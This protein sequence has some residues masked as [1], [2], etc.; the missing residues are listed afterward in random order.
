M[1][2]KDG[3]HKALHEDWEVIRSDPLM[4]IWWV[5]GI[6]CILAGFLLL[7]TNPPNLPLGLPAFALGFAFF[8]FGS[9]RYSNII[10]RKKL[11][12]INEKLKNIEAKE[13]SLKKM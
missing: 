7:S 11:D 2:V 6:G 4:V 13:D 5:L 3:F 10:L 9:N 1:T 8:I 12:T